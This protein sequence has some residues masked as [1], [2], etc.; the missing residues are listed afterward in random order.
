MIQVVA[1]DWGC[2]V[3]SGFVLCLWADRVLL[4]KQEVDLAAGWGVPCLW[5]L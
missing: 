5:L 3:D 2:P 1:A 4:E